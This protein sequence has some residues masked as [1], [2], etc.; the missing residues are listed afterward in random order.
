MRRYP[1]RRGTIAAVM[2]TLL[3]VAGGAAPR[4]AAAQ[5]GLADQAALFLLLPV[6]A[7]AVG[8]GHAMAA[9]NGTSDAV[10]WN[11]SG[12]AAI[13]KRDA[14]L[15]HSQSV[16]GRGDALTFAV[17]SSLLGVVALSANILDFGGEIPAVDNQ[18][19][20]VGTILPRN[21]AAVA[22]YATEIG[23]RVRTGVSYKL[24]QF[25]FDCRGQCPDLPTSQASTNALDIG[26]QY[27]FQ[28]RLPITVG[29]VIRNIGVSLQVKDN[30]QSDPL[31]TRLQIGAAARYALP[32]EVAADAEVR[33][34][35]DLIGEIP[36]GTP[37]P[38]FGAE[39][40]WEKRAFVR[41][42]Y[43]VEAANTESGGPSLGLGFVAGR[44]VIDF[45]RVFT[46]L[47]VDAGQAPTHLSLRVTF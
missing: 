17:S 19:N 6:G 12:I 23:K 16:F 10:W 20:Q 2:T 34:A 25:R 47:S 14:S 15:H 24:V 4:R 40:G 18:G 32:K 8:V 7:R 45:A 11:P 9:A 30:P 1:S 26:V 44:F 22:T 27:D 46:G 3:A 41:A 37:L 31:P 13:S 28:S 21:I 43:V 39:F 36:V 35:V 5:G 33:L 29:A 42:G 38:R